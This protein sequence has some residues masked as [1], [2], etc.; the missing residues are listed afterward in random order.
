MNSMITYEKAGACDIEPIYC[1]CRQLIDDYE[2]IE[3]IDYDKV[4][5]WVRRKIESSIDEYN[6]VFADGRKAGYYRFYRNEDGEYEIDDLYIF[7]EYR[8]RG[9]GTEIIKKCCLSADAPVTLYVFIR[10]ERAAA[11]YRRLGFEIVQTV[12]GSR[13]VMR[14]EKTSARS[15]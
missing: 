13:Y 11:L 15:V 2:N 5:K 7:R 6:A 12:N 14:K 10:N 3:S 1:L 9:I 8:N 4:L